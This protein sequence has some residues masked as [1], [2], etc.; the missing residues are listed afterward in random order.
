MCAV[1]GSRAC[2]IP[3]TPPPLSAY[4]AAMPGPL[5][6]VRVLDSTTVV[7]GP[8]AAQTLGDLGADVIKIEPPEGDT[9]RQLGPA[10][11]PGMAAFYLGCNRNKRSLVLDFKQPAGRQAL[12][13]LARDAD[14]LMHNFRPQ[15]AARLGLEYDK[16]RSVNPRL[17]YCATYGFRA[18]GPYG[19]KP[20]YDDIIQAASGLTSLQA[21]LTGD[22]RYLPT[23]VADKTS[24]MAV[25]SSVLAALFHRER[26]GQG[27]ALEVPMFESVAAWVMV[28]HLY[29]E[30]FVPALGSAGYKR[31]L[32]RWRRP[33]PTKDG[34][35]AVLPYTDANWKSFFALAGRLDLLQD[36]R[37]SSLATRLANIEPLYEE[38]GKIVA[39]RTNAEWLE[40]LEGANV[41]AMVVNT[42]E[43]LLR[44]PQLEATGFWRIVEH[45]TEGTLRTPDIP[46]NF[47]ETPGEIRRLPPRLGEH[48][49]D[50]LRETGFS[51]SEIDAMLASGATRTP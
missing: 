45:P 14:V 24:S 23:I 16:F 44:D 46:T 37:Y 1:D 30:T 12:F 32:N 6:G 5:A 20:A 3:A 21:P 35:L 29:G 27:Q 28:E 2:G 48:S 51:Q 11:H 9:T 15:I 18:T 34:Y 26:T 25:L 17:V 19:S 31:I 36:P 13:R 39:T 8:L 49:I 47:S 41:P 10:R 50:V 42:L 40:A 7:L 43:T 38:L 33:F 22:P 4:N